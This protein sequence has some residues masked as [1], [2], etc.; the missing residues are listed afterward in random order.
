MNY[1][2]ISKKEGF[3]DGAKKIQAESKFRSKDCEVIEIQD[4]LKLKIQDTRPLLYCLTNKSSILSHVRILEERGF[5][6]VNFK[7]I[8]GGMLKFEVQQSMKLRGI[9]VPYSIK[10]LRESF[11]VNNNLINYPLYIK[12]QRQAD[13]VLYCK[14]YSQ[15]L[16]NL[17]S[18]K[19]EDTYY[20]EEAV[21]DINMTLNK[22]YYI[23]G[24]V[25]N[26]KEISGYKT[27]GWIQEILA[28]ISKALTLEVFS[29]D[30]FIDLKNK[31]YLCIDINPASAFFKSDKGREVFIDKIFI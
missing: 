17:A 18:L 27:P 24:T 30:M 28:N 5:K 6:I 3:E 4:L 8:L 23:K 2:L 10:P 11:L 16:A 14:N 25:V 26:M 15:G 1:I 19:I 9:K 21:E 20:I 12:S 29:A 22:F 31:E 7:G 13:A